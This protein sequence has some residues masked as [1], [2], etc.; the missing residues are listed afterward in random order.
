M[1]SFATGQ[2]LTGKEFKLDWTLFRNDNHAQVEWIE[3]GYQ[4]ILTDSECLEP[5]W[6]V[7]EEKIPAKNNLVHDGL[8]LHKSFLI[9]LE[10]FATSQGSV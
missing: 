6:I 1:L 4:K 5:I 7:R 9:E 10:I 3:I 2:S 8:T